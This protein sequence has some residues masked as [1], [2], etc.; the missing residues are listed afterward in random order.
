MAEPDSQPP[1]TRRPRGDAQVALLAGYSLLA[2]AATGRS[3]YEL[4]VKFDEAPFAYSLS[5]FAALVYLA[6]V[7]AIRRGDRLGL[8]IAAAACSFE[9]TGV[10]VVGALSVIDPDTFDERTVWTKFGIDYGFLPLAMPFL[11]LVWIAREWRNG[12]ASR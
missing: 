11:A 2:F 4:I 9:M 8:R 12:I 6:A 3:T 7:W 1:R 10:L 5:T